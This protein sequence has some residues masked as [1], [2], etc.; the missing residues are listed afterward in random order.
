[1]AG[2]HNGSLEA[3]G[4]T[5]EVKRTKAG[6]QD[7]KGASFQNKKGNGELRDNNQAEHKSKTKGNQAKSPKTKESIITTKTVKFKSS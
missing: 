6:N 3:A 4:G 7:T 5:G 1:M 2:S